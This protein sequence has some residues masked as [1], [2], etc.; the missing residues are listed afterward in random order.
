MI[1]HTLLGCDR[2]VAAGIAAAVVFVA[3][4]CDAR[5]SVSR[6]RASTRDSSGVRIVEYRNI[7]SALSAFQVADSP[8]L[9]LGGLRSDP[10]DEFN[11]G[12]PFLSAVRLSDGRIVVA[13]WA[14]L[15]F[16]DSSGTLVR[17][18]GR[19]GTG[20]GEFTQLGKICRL[21]GDTLLAID[22]SVRRVSLW[23][24]TG[25]LVR[26]FARV[27]QVA[28]ESCFPDGTLVLPDLSGKHLPAPD[29]SPGPKAL[30]G[31]VNY[32]RIRPEGAVVQSLGPHPRSE[33]VGGTVYTVRVIA[34]SNRFYVGD[35]HRYELRVFD[36]NSSLRLIV[37]V[38]DPL[39]EEEM[40]SIQ[41][42]RGARVGADDR[43]G[44]R[45]PRSR[46]TRPAFGDIRV[47]PA[48][49]I[50][51]QSYEPRHRW[52]VWD[53]LGT[54]LGKIEPEL[55]VPGGR[56]PSLVGAETNHV[57]FREWDAD[58]A[59]HLRFYRITPIR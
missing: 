34:G 55:K 22:W 58:N 4:A 54:L 56:H 46:V 10:N 7:R 40:R 2:V 21:P 25:K 20:P 42:P 19:Q 8:F 29:S 33:M 35:P 43:A 32:L 9:D 36:M 53:S 3:T 48:G 51:V 17:S 6:P 13:D 44:M 49:R 11:P 24:S 57:V 23:D 15:M 37:R 28:V 1:P 26:A 59:V 38:T 5:F 31:T 30:A 14:R 45:P 41:P 50:W 12:H 52:I 27:G 47:D 16:F 18:V 39:P